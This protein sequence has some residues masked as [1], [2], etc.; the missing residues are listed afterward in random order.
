M[1]KAEWKRTIVEQSKSGRSV[2]EFCRERKISEGSFWYWRRKLGGEKEDPTFVR[3][4]GGELVELE[5][6][7]GRTIRTRR[8]DLKAV[9]EALCDR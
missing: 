1:T 7:G 5:L 2:S 6:P 9:L 4:D 3:I 8:G